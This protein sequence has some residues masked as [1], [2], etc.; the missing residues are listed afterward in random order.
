MIFAPFQSVDFVSNCLKLIVNIVLF[1]A[2]I[3]CEMKEIP[4]QV[5]FIKNACVYEALR[6]TSGTSAHV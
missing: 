4:I 5:N 6:G 2:E 3:D 1:L